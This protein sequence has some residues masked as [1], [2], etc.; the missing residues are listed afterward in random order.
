MYLDYWELQ[1]TPFGNVPDS[2]IFFESP[3]HEEAL[4]RLLYAVQQK[5][6][7][8]MLTGEVG[9][10]KTTVSRAF[11]SRVSNDNYDVH[12][13]TNPALSA[14]DL[15][16]AIL[17]KL[18]EDADSDSKSVLLARLQDR[19]MQNA[20]QDLNTVLIIDEAHIIDDRS[21]FEE[22]RMLLNIQSENQLLIT[23]ILLGQPPLLNKIAALQPLNERIGIK[24]HLEPLSANNTMRY[25]AFRL[26]SAGAKRGIFTK[27]SIGLIY[28]NSSGIPLKINN[29]CD[30]SLLIGMIA[31]ARVIH[32]GIIKEAV[33]D[34]R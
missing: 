25:L 5:K 3:Q 26:R 9:A 30:R 2:R 4:F 33:E 24:Y 11:I 8:A 20:V 10:G 7:V 28:E 29:I 12:T 14:M 21:T 13:I 18:G 32:S 27:D 22:L 6:G 1:R 34:L 31:S 15:I 19:L 16:R 17:L 23:L